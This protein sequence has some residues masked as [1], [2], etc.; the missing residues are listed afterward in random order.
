MRDVEDPDTGVRVKITTPAQRIVN[1][2]GIVSPSL[3][4]FLQELMIFMDNQGFSRAYVEKYR[5]GIRIE[6]IPGEDQAQR[7]LPESF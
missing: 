4:I 2:I 3:N 6:L 5:K 1:K 7:K